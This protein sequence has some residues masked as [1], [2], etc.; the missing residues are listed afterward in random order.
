M[1]FFNKGRAILDIERAQRTAEESRVV[2]TAFEQEFLA[3]T[4]GYA[5]LKLTDLTTGSSF[6]DESFNRIRTASYIQ[7]KRYSLNPKSTTWVVYQTHPTVYEIQDTGLTASSSVWMTEETAGYCYIV[8]TDDDTTLTVFQFDGTSLSEI[9]LSSS[10]SYSTNT[11]VATLPSGELIVF[12]AGTSYAIVSQNGDVT[13]GTHLASAVDQI[14]VERVGNAIC[15]IGVT[16]GDIISGVT[17][18]GQNYKNWDNWTTGDRSGDDGDTNSSYAVQSGTG[19]QIVDTHVQTGGFSALASDGTNH[20]LFIATNGGYQIIEPDFSDIEADISQTLTVKDKANSTIVA[21]GYYDR[22]LY[23]LV[24]DNQ[25]TTK[26]LSAYRGI[27]SQS[28]TLSSIE[29]SSAITLPTLS[30]P[31]RLYGLRES[32]YQNSDTNAAV[33]SV[34]FGTGFVSSNILSAAEADTLQTVTDRG[35]TTTNEIGIPSVQFDTTQTLTP[36]SGQLG[37]NADDETLDLGLNGGSV[38]HKLGETLFFNVKAAEAISKG[39]VLYASGAVGNSG[40]IEASKYTANNTIDENRVLGVAAEDISIGDF[41]FVYFLGSLRGITTDGSDVSETWV[42]GT[43]LYASPS[44]AG[45]LTSTQPVAP[46]QDIPIAFVTSAHATNGSLYIRATQLGYH[47]EEIHDVYVPSPSDGEVLTWS[48][49]NQRW[50]ASAAAGGAEELNDL[51]DVTISSVADGEILQYDSATGDFL[52][53]DEIF[54]DVDHDDAVIAPRHLFGLEDVGS[55]TTNAVKTTP[56]QVYN[57]GTVT[58]VPEGAWKAVGGLGSLGF[59]DYGKNFIKHGQQVTWNAF[60]SITSVSGPF[61]APPYFMFDYSSSDLDN[62]I[63]DFRLRSE[64]SNSGDAIGICHVTG[65]ASRNDDGIWTAA[66]GFIGGGTGIYFY[67]TPA[68]YLDVNNFTVGTELSISLN[69]ATAYNEFTDQIVPEFTISDTT[70][71]TSTTVEF[72]NKSL[73]NP[74]TFTGAWNITG[75]PYTLQNGTTLNDEDIDVR[76][77]QVLTT[78][79]ITF[80]PSRSDKGTLFT[81]SKTITT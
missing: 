77:D 51:T 67:R 14:F 65:T 34:Y 25:S 74:D 52:N 79:T 24:L 28:K 41:G 45:A 75:G 21:H 19:I 73:G 69:Y 70:P 48:N 63:S 17:V 43:I 31:E 72:R 1:E 12:T 59:L 37:W 9:T 81:A 5:E 10:I 38:V 80:N 4:G 64:T 71:T 35:A 18:D 6:V 22:D 23:T 53:T 47:L 3:K 11:D 32:F 20:Y 68:N 39:D 42:D 15:F 76:F 62:N 27:L 26:T 44:T 66:W 55:G 13:S 58:E 50:E 8:G 7:D 2:N 46:N 61:V 56:E 49:S 57:S 33:F 78:Y 16:S 40:K 30:A 29:Q 54:F 36:T 60:L